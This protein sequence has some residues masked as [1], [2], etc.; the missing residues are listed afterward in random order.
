[1]RWDNA[2]NSGLP[3]WLETVWFSGLMNCPECSQPIFEELS[4]SQSIEQ[5][6]TP[7]TGDFT[8]VVS[9]AC[10]QDPD[11]GRNLTKPT[12]Q[13]GDIAL[14]IHDPLDQHQTV[15]RF[16]GDKINMIRQKEVTIQAWPEQ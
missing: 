13:R 11:Q 2:P 15:Y 9:A 4:G 7:F 8:G 6:L 5:M 3:Q 1:M 12:T 10:S 14:N 16:R